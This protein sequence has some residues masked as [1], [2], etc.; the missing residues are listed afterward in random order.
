MN[1][2]FW[3]TEIILSVIL[4]VA[5]TPRSQRGYVIEGKMSGLTDRALYIVTGSGSAT[6]ID[7]VITQNG[8]FHF[9]AFSESICP[10]VIY[11]EEKSVWFTVYVQNGDEIELSGHAGY[12]ELIQ[13]NGNKI[14]DLLTGFHQS[15]ADIF[16]ALNDSTGNFN[17]DSLCNLLREKAQTVIRENPQSIASL[18]LI[19]DHLIDSYDP[20]LIGEYLSLIE[21]PAKEDTLYVRLTNF[22]SR[23]ERTKTGTLPSKASRKRPTEKSPGIFYK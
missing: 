11:L 14:N 5:C 17:P 18:V 20:K 9:S 22:C 3:I 10:V 8:E 6:K 23:L 7:T 19:Q 13:I 12:P 1:F 16:E 4:F 15:N 21:T 2:R